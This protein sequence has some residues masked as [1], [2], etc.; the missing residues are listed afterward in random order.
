MSEITAVN[1]SSWSH[2][3][4]PPQI[5]TYTAV[6]KG[7]EKKENKGKLWYNH[8]ASIGAAAMVG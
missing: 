5:V 7:M 3:A 2:E 4:A 8:D 1:K 6:E